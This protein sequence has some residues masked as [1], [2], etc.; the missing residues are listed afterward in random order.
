MLM[1][2][3][4][5]A[6]LVGTTPDFPPLHVPALPP[7][8]SLPDATRLDLNQ[9]G[10][11]DSFGVE[12]SKAPPD[13]PRSV[14]F[15]FRRPLTPLDLERFTQAGGVLRWVFQ[16][17]SYG[18]W[19]SITPRRL[20]A[21]LAA[22]REGVL[23]V[24]GDGRMVLDLDRATRNARARAV[25]ASGFAG[26]DA[27][28]EGSPSTTIAIIDTG[29]D[30]S[31]P[32][33]AGRFAYWQDFQGTE[34]SPVDLEGHGSCVASVALGSG[35]AFEASAPTLYMTRGAAFEGIAAGSVAGRTPMSVDQPMTLSALGYFD[36]AATTRLA[37]SSSFAPVDGTRSYG[38]V[39]SASGLS[40]IAL[41]TTLMPVA[42]QV[43]SLGL[44][45]SS[46]ASLT[47]GNITSSLSPW[48]LVGDGKPTMRGVA[49]G[50]RWAS[51]HA[52]DNVMT[53]TMA[54]D[55]LTSKRQAINLKV[56][57]LSQSPDTMGPTLLPAK[58]KTLA[59]GGVLIVKTSGNTGR[60]ATGVVTPSGMTALALTVGA[61]NL[62]NQ[63]TSYTSAGAFTV[64]VD[65]DVKP[66]LL[67]PG[68]S[69]LAIDMKCVDSNDADKP[70]GGVAD[71]VANDYEF[72]EGTSFAAP[73]ISGAAGLVIQA[74]EAHGWVWDWTS[75]ASPRQ[76]KAL[77]MATA[78]ETNQP[79]EAPPSMDP[80]LG[81][82]AN[83]KDRAEGYGVVN[84][85]AAIEAVAVPLSLPLQGETAGGPFDRR[86]WARTVALVAGTPIS[87][88][89]LVPPASDFD[90]YLYSATPDAKGNPV[91]LAFADTATL[92]GIERLL[93]T[94]TTTEQAMVVV[95][96]ISGAGSWKLVATPTC[97]NGRQEDGEACDDGNTVDG[98]CCSATC[99]AEP[100]GQQC[101]TGHCVTGICEAPPCGDRQLAFPETC[102]D[103]NTRTGDCCSPTCTI[104]PDGTACFGG[105]CVAGLCTAPLKSPA[106][107]GEAISGPA[108]TT[109]SVAA[110]GPAVLLL[111][112]GLLRR[113][114]R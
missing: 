2:T 34:S 75:S 19:G 92:G 90:L 57:N 21:L 46:T 113:R 11:E 31:H 6:L 78:T 79:R 24:A 71:Y 35:A 70:D 55:D 67:A 49:P 69:L 30:D 53:V 48:P 1:P 104:D 107:A 61:T 40:P 52:S 83:Q 66:D 64:G 99:L 105:A 108:S 32:D 14:E 76:V 42:G 43:L 9:D 82:G 103:G 54:L 65:E 86:A 33:L 63:L 50:C 22:N 17:V 109:C 44:V 93:W 16:S 7:R 106:I 72:E 84:V 102:D 112:L 5:G 29:I 4:V 81:R 94:P 74:L 12:L 28:Y 62:G 60:Q 101:P 73:V 37:V 39:T 89:L 26:S 15:V 18:F 3:L 8:V 38:T 36:G 58:F 95:K 110:S 27:G 77:L 111:A 56:I 13:V 80:P 23:L 41:N 47:W 45:Q 88:S 96:R 68:G 91:L 51:A 114:R 98:D 100:T 25:W 10:L 85:D 20:K 97:G 59:E 87:W